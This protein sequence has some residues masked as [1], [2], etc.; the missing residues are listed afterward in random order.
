MELANQP[1]DINTTAAAPAR[2]RAAAT[3]GDLATSPFL[4]ASSSFRGEA[5][6][7]F[8][9]GSGV[10]ATGASDEDIGQGAVAVDEDRSNDAEAE[11]EDRQAQ[12]DAQ[13]GGGE[14]DLE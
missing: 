13:R 9:S 5:S 2:E 3:S 8:E 6:S 14:E 10:S 11:G 1:P 4:R 7:V 12:Q